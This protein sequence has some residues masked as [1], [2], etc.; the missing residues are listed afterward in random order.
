[1]GGRGAEDLQTLATS[2][3]P[4]EPIYHRQTD[5]TAGFIT[6]PERKQRVQTRIRLVLPLAVATRTFCRLGSQRRRFL[7]W[8]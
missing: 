8:A 1:M 6:A 4:L 3:T 5:L 2:T 7:L